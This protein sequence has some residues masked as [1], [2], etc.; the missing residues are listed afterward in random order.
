MLFHGSTG[1]EMIN[2]VCEDEREVAEQLVHEVLKRLGGI[3]ETK[4]HEKIP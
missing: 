1:D 3:G 4:R 2:K